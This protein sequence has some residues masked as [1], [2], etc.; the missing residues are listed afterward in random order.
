MPP[1]QE[2]RQR[3]NC[4]QC[5]RLS[6]PFGNTVPFQ[7]GRFGTITDAPVV[8]SPDT[9]SNRASAGYMRAT[10]RNG[11]EAK[12]SAASQPKATVAK[13]SRIP[14]FPLS[15]WRFRVAKIPVRPMTTAVTAQ[16][17]NSATS[18]T[19]SCIRHP[20]GM[21]TS[22]AEPMKVVRMEIR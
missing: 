7:R 4:T 2:I 16:T 9:V 20:T 5:G 1:S 12:I 22:I 21:Q 15:A 13:P 6:T 17:A 3:Q 8:V 14:A 10:N 11:S 19:G 18:G